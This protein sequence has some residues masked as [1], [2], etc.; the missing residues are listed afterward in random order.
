MLC[1]FVFGYIFLLFQGCWWWW[2]DIS[3]MWNVIH[4][5]ETFSRIGEKRG[6][7]SIS[8]LSVVLFLPFFLSLFIC[9][10]GL[11][12]W[13]ARFPTEF[14]IIIRIN[15]STSM[16]MG[17]FDVFVFFSGQIYIIFVWVFFLFTFMV[18]STNLFMCF[19]CL[20]WSFLFLTDMVVGHGQPGPE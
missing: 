15:G 3:L 13:Y 4:T 8:K 2:K 10:N 16:V 1:V 7:K 18:I 5:K 11:L 9:W 14:S 6:K 12:L 17:F 19:I 20:I